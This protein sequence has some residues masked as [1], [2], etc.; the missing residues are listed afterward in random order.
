MLTGLL[1]IIAVLSDCF[2]SAVIHS[3]YSDATV[4]IWVRENKKAGNYMISST[5][6]GPG[7]GLACQKLPVPGLLADIMLG[8]A[9]GAELITPIVLKKAMW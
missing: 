6:W 4:N 7:Y 8:Q 9:E 1:I 3:V 2:Q 5:S